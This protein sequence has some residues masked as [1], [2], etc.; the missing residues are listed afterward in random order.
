[1]EDKKKINSCQ[2]PIVICR[3]STFYRSQALKKKENQTWQVDFSI[4]LV[5]HFH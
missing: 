3:R 1:M 4:H 2:L 5:D